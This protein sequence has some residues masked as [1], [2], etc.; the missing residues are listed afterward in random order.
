MMSKR[1]LTPWFSGKVEPARVGVYERQLEEFNRFSYWDGNSW[2][3]ADWTPKA[4]RSS[5]KA[6]GASAWQNAKWRGL[7]SDPAKNTR[8]DK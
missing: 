6:F 8:G 7:A 4:A 5:A 3:C 2:G 1:D